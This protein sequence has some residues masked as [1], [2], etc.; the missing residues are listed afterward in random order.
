MRLTEMNPKVACL[1]FLCRLVPLMSDRS[2]QVLG[3]PKRCGQPLIAWTALNY[4]MN[5]GQTLCVKER[6]RG[7]ILNKSHS[8]PGRILCQ[9]SSSSRAFPS[10]GSL[11]TGSRLGGFK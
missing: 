10:D 1:A 4:Q 6:R 9:I 8:Y 5:Y 11:A 3:L 2:N 7:I